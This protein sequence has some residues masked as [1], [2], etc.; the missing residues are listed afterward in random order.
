MRLLFGDVVGA[1]GSK[2]RV[3]YTGGGFGK[4]DDDEAMPGA[5]TY[6]FGSLEYVLRN[7]IAS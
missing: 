1:G 3:Q 5:D 2:G 6:C 7:Q 4:G